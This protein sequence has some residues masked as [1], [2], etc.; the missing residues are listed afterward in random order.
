MCIS[1]RTS[2]YFYLPCFLKVLLAITISQT[3]HV[4]YDLDG[5]WVL[6]LR[7]FVKYPYTWI[8]LM[9]FSWSHWVCGLGGEKTQVYDIFILF[10][11]TYI[12]YCN[13]TCHCQYWP[14]AP[15]SGNVC[16]VS[17]QKAILFSLF[18]YG[19]FFLSTHKEK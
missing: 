12:I 1:S 3:F 5:F 14:W 11:S 10:K 2:H 7:S 19:I 6:P 18:P 17:P 15:G 9:V 8:Y 4:A 16:H 13:I